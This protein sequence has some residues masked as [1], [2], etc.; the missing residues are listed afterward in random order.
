[1]NEGFVEIF[2]EQ[3]ETGDVLDVDEGTTSLALVEGSIVST[4][5][6]EASSVSITRMFFDMY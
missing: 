3:S 4:I 1:L 6:N 2:A 5:D